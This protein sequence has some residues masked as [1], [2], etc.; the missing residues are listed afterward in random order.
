[1]KI[2]FNR[3]GAERKALVQAAGEILGVKPKYLGMPTAAYEVGCFRIDRNGTVEPDGCVGSREIES[4]LERLAEKGI[5]PVPSETAQEADTDALAET[6]E[7]LRRGRETGRTGQ[8]RGLQWH[9]RGS[10]SQMPRWRTCT[11]WWKRKAGLSKRRW[12]PAAL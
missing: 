1:M 5:A 8:I 3:T 11:G 7:K 9:F 6:V 12:G 2:E 10:R 4:L